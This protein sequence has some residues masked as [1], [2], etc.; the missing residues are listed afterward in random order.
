M[1][2]TVL[3]LL[4]LACTGCTVASLPFEAV[5]S[6]LDRKP[7]PGSPYAW[8]GT[9]G[10]PCH[11]SDPVWT[12]YPKPNEQSAPPSCAPDPN[13]SATFDASCARCHYGHDDQPA[14]APDLGNSNDVREF[15]WAGISIV[16]K[17]GRPDKGMPAARL[18]DCQI[19]GLAKWIKSQQY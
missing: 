7:C 9:A 14:T 19:D 6:A 8:D 16:I 13:P 17:H 10:S 12:Y 5:F 18:N 2:R 3:T 4:L 11:G 1:R 15:S